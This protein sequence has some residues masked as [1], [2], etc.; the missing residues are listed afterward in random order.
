MDEREL[1]EYSQ[2]LMIPVYLL[3]NQAIE[4]L[5]DA[6]S[7]S[8]ISYADIND[9]LPAEEDSFSLIRVPSEENGHFVFLS[10][11]GRRIL[12][13]ND[14]CW[15]ITSLSNTSANQ[16]QDLFRVSTA[17]GIMLK[18]ANDINHLDTEQDIYEFILDNCGR[19]VQHSKLC[20]LMSVKDDVAKIVAK[21]G[22]DDDV[23]NVSFKLN[24]TFIGMV[25]EQK[26]DRTI[27]INDLDAFQSIY[28]KQVKP[29][30]GNHYLCSTLSAP[31]YVNQQLYAIL[32][33]DSLEKNAFTNQD[34]ELL[35]LVKTNIET[36]LTNHQMQMEI[37]HLSKTDQL[38]GL[39]NRTYLI[40][41]L[42]EHTKDSFYVGM[43]DMNDLKGINDGHG[44]SSGDFMIR[45]MADT[46]K[47][48]FPEQAELF[49][50]GGDEFMC[51]VYQMSLEEI[52]KKIDDLR[53][54]LKKTPLILPDGYIASLSFSCGFACH[55]ANTDF[56]T[57]LSEADHAMYEE[58]RRLKSIRL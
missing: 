53:E 32:C 43:M 41:Y 39:Y 8:A 17:R 29:T 6:A 26:F 19:A 45:E 35:E 25:T 40:E 33:F 13:G 52:Q 51:I 58:K 3:R 44:H 50:L 14:V 28:Y 48:T 24:E 36:M 7:A 56:D 42:K 5:N 18:M 15:L 20:S 47:T 54:D 38:T 49:R 22:Y 55:D 11:S 46:L 23:F 10:F 31:I 16:I 30:E 9:K 27:V 12:L 2:L 37:L 57:V 1:K 4:P 21:R 34:V